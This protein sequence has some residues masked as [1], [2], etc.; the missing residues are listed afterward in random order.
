[1]RPAQKRT[2]L[3]PNPVHLRSFPLLGSHPAGRWPQS[4]AGDTEAARRA[5]VAHSSRGRFHEMLT[6]A[7]PRFILNQF[8]SPFSQNWQLFPTPAVNDS[9]G[10]SSLFLFSHREVTIGKVQAPGVLQRP[11]ELPALQPPAP[12]ACYT[13]GGLPAARGGACPS[14]W[15]RGWETSKGEE[16]ISLLFFFQ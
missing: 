12:Q 2:T 5:G 8:N 14:N 13:Q 10:A 16:E 4:K 9:G 6:A 1:M 7:S 11:A 15:E 3:V